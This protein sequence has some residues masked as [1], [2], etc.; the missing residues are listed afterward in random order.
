MHNDYKTRLNAL[1]DKLT[2]V[3]LKE[4]ESDTWPGADCLTIKLFE[5]EY[6]IDEKRRRCTAID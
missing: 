6:R 2:D 4:A 1:S 5:K 3:V